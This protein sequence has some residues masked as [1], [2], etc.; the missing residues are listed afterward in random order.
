MKKN[1]LLKIF[2]FLNIV[3]FFGCDS[4]LTNKEKMS[5]EKNDISLQKKENINENNFPLIDTIV[6]NNVISQFKSF[7]KLKNEFSIGIA[8]KIDSLTQ[9]I[10]INNLVELRVKYPNQS[11]KY[12]HKNIGNCRKIGLLDISIS[13]MSVL[14]KEF[15]QLQD[16]EQL[17]IYN[18]NC[19]K[20][21]FDMS[22]LTKLRA[23]TIYFDERSNYDCFIK[24]LSKVQKHLSIRL[25]M[26]KRLEKNAII[27]LSKIKNLI[28]IEIHNREYGVH[29]NFIDETFKNI[30]N[31]KIIKEGYG[32]GIDYRFTK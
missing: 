22:K 6:R 32:F 21:N 23:I 31:I 10:F 13:K 5:I 18:N 26:Q 20:I 2:V 25:L 3:I 24:E 1:K 19:D 9:E 16:L 4:K 14:P 27:L 15:E 17:D 12:I 11:I 7:G 28:F 30:K 29:D 8:K